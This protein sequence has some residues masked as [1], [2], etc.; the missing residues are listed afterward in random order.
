MY[1]SDTPS[2]DDYLIVDLKT[3][4]VWYEGMLASQDA[5]NR[6]YN[7]D[8]YKGKDA[9]GAARLVLRKVPQGVYQTGDNVNY[10]TSNASKSWRT[11]RTYYVGVF[12]VTQYQ[13]KELCGSNPAQKTAEIAG[14]PVEQRPV[15][16]VSWKTL[17]GAIAPTARIPFVTSKTGTFFQRLNYLTGN[18]YYFDLPTEVMSE[19]AQRAGATTVYSWGASLDEVTRY[20]VCKNNSNA[21][22]VAVGSRD[23]NAWGLYDTAGNVWELCLDAKGL[24]N[25]ALA[26]DPFTP[27]NNPSS[28]VRRMR[29]GGNWNADYTTSFDF[30]ASRRNEFGSVDSVS[31][32][33][34]F[35]V[36]FIV[37]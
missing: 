11:Y 37:D 18:R 35:R 16:Y 9:Q 19:I 17:R 33:V 6:R 8:L 36:A 3:G 31:P 28:T 12:P 26:V 1:P 13:Y 2:G 5:S 32:G 23:P 25:L 10:S 29:G 21:S 4:E 27:H 34:G 7:T 30:R 22:T 15:E 24:A 14:N 20:C